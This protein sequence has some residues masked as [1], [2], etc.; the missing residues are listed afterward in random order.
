[1]IEK[2]VKRIRK[3]QEEISNQLQHSTR[4]SKKN[5]IEVFPFYAATI[6][7]ERINFTHT[8]KQEG[9]KI[10]LSKEEHYCVE[11]MKKI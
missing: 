8:I 3:E 5:G 4:S 2:M 11:K 1:M 7:K 10:K 6:E 9:V